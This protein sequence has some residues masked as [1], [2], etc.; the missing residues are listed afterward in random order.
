MIFAVVLSMAFTILAFVNF[1]NII[2]SNLFEGLGGKNAE[3][4]DILVQIISI[5][6]IR[7]PAAVVDRFKTL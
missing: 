7:R 6:L 5:V 3:Y 4:I 1:Q 2:Y